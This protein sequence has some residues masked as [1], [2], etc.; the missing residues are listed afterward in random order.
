MIDSHC[1]LWFKHFEGKIPEF[2]QRAKEAG[3]D[4]MICVGCDEKSSGQ[5]VEIA[6]E[7]EGVFAA[8]GMHPT[9]AKRQ[10]RS[11]N[12][13]EKMRGNAPDLSWIKDLV[14]NSNKV[15]AIGETGLD[16]YHEPYDKE[17]QVKM[18]KAHCE[19][20]KEYDLPV[21][22]HMRSGKE[23]PEQD[24]LKVLD[25]MEMGEDKVI[26]HCFAGD[27]A[28]AEEVIKRA[29][30]ISFA[31]PVTYPNAES[32]REVARM[33]P[34]D[35]VLTETDCPFLTPQKYRGGKNEPAYVV[36][37]ARQIA[38][39][40]EISYDDFDILVNENVSRVFKI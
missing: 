33:V 32:L 28:F 39:L 26:F 23:N 1:H 37:V 15:I 18:F 35:R 21:V 8:V 30:M 22:V 27:V 12:L 19:I 24:C 20:A 3:V 40:R 16:Y 10:P 29:W 2:L 9:D 4:K 6:E 14:E 36:E 17:M 13:D 38:N 31:G 5:S 11:P 7:Y 25:E 34:L